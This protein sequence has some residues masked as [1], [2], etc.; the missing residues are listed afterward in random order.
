MLLRVN[1][2]DLVLDKKAFG[3]DIK[4]EVVKFLAV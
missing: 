4:H 2:D 1:E 3:L